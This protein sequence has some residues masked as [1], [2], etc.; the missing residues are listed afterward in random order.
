MPKLEDLPHE[1]VADAVARAVVD[2]VA[3]GGDTEAIVARALATVR[4]NLGLGADGSV[5]RTAPTAP[6]NTRN[7]GAAPAPTYPRAAT[8]GS[9]SNG[10]GSRR[11]VTEADVLAAARAGQHELRIARRSIVTALARDVA[12]DAGVTLVEE[13]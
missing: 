8:P 5:A 3:G 4:S 7:I 13:G 2:S 9:A 11:V 1:A 6:A 12:H 10:A